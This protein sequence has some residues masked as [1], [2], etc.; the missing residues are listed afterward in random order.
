MNPSESLYLDNAAT[1]W[2]K[3]DCV[4]DA[5]DQYARENGRAV[6]RGA[7]DAS[8]QLQKIVERCRHRAAGLLGA[9]SKNEIVFTFNCTDSLNTILHGTLRE[10][11]HVVTSV[12]EHNSVLRPLR[13]LERTRGVSVTTVDVDQVEIG[14]ASCR[15][16]V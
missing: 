13:Q 7:T 11:D 1:S 4:Y 3:P 12:A 2:P 6:G 16:R 8:L 15:E 9:A 14:R 5:V 10:G